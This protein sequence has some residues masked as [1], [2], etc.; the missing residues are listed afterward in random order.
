GSA[1][2]SYHLCLKLS[3][4]N[5]ERRDA[6]HMSVNAGAANTAGTMKSAIAATGITLRHPQI[7]LTK[8]SINLLKCLAAQKSVLKT[9]NAPFPPPSTSSQATTS[10]SS[11]SARYA[12]QPT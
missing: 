4:K 12:L 1:Q 2:R 7:T 8:Q 9:R 10:R 11:I 6:P 3:E 5:S